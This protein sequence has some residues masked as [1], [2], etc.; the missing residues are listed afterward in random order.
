MTTYTLNL[1]NLQIILHFLRFILLI[2]SAIMFFTTGW[3]SWWYTYDIAALAMFLWTCLNDL[4]MYVT[5]QMMQGYFYRLFHIRFTWDAYTYGSFLA[6]MISQIATSLSVVAST[7][8]L[9][10]DGHPWSPIDGLRWSSF[11]I[12]LIILVV[13]NATI[14]ILHVYLWMKGSW[15]CNRGVKDMRGPSKPE[16]RVSMFGWKRP[17]RERRRFGGLL[18]RLFS[19]AIFRRIEFV[20]DLIQD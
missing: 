3:G 14:L 1:V 10:V 2:P 19:N 13:V 5:M 11:L 15:S 6:T 9:L 8:L 17:D 18:P 4:Y 20:I 16:S 12:I 7:I